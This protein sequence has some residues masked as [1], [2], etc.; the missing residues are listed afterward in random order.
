MSPRLGP[1]RLVLLQV[2]LTLRA[3]MSA[4]SANRR[5]VCQPKGAEI[6]SVPP[7]NTI[8]DTVSCSGAV[9]L[10]RSK[11]LLSGEMFNVKHESSPEVHPGA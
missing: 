7:E 3:V 5:G 9:G 2:L 6:T 8:T 10:T 1:L 11:A 4:A